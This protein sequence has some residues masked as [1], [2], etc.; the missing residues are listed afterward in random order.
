MVR[1]KTLKNSVTEKIQLNLVQNQ[2]KLAKLNLE[3]D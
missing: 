1:F 2:L 3:Q